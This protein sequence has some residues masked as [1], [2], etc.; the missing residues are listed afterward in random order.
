[1][2]IVVL[3]GS[4]NR[5]GST[6]ILVREFTRGA[7]EKKFLKHCNHLFFAVHLEK[8]GKFLIVSDI[9]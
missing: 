4:P 3:M 6:N 7:E 5:N 8:P 1:M 9:Y 2:K